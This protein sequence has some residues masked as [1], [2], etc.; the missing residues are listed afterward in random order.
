MYNQLISINENLKFEIEKITNFLNTI[1]MCYITAFTMDGH[2][3]GHQYVMLYN[4][5]YNF[6]TPSL[7]SNLND[8]LL[9]IFN[10]EQ[11]LDTCRNPE[12][13]LEKAKTSSLTNTT[14]HNCRH[15]DPRIKLSIVDALHLEIC[16]MPLDNIL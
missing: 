11:E 7:T 16:K 8:G 14:I 2:A 10:L 6:N 3:C 5:K 1:S 15:A 9:V 4:N 12:A 13:I